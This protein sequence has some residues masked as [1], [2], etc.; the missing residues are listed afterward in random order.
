MRYI[1]AKACAEN[2]LPCFCCRAVSYCTPHAS[3]MHVF[4]LSL[5]SLA[6]CMWWIS[7]APPLSQTDASAEGKRHGQGW[8]CASPEEFTLSRNSDHEHYISAN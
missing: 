3:L 8:V 2:E 6:F 4:L 7:N 1:E 5:H